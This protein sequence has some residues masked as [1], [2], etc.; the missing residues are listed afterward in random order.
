MT[1]P[2]NGQTLMVLT[3]HP[4]R[5]PAGDI[6]WRIHVP[7]IYLQDARVPGGNSWGLSIP[8]RSHVG[9][10]PMVYILF[11]IERHGL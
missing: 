5:S 9:M 6:G 2:S 4:P 7:M 8:C 3:K 10:S 11:E 1:Y